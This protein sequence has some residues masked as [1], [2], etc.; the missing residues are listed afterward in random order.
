M[1][2][3]T[4]TLALFLWMISVHL[5]SV[6]QSKSSAGN[7]L[8]PGWYADPEVS[9]FGKEVWIYPTFSAK[10]EQQVFLDAFSSPDLVHWKKHERIIDT[11]AV[12]WAKRA[13]WAPAIVEKGGKYYLFF[14]ANDIQRDG[15][16][17]GIGVAV[18][19]RPEGPFKDLP[20][21]PLIDRFHN[22]AQ[23]IDQFVFED[24]GQWYMI[25]GGWRHCNIV[26]LKEDFTGLLPFPDGSYFRE[27]TPEGYVEGP[28]MFKRNGKYYFMW[29]EGGWTGP[30]Y[31]VAYAISDNP[32]GPFK[33][34]GK[35]LQ[36][37]PAVATG[38]GHHS[39]LHIKENDGY[40]IVY[41]RRPLGETDGNARQ[42]CID[43]LRFDAEG[44]IMPVKIT[45]E[46]VK[47]VKLK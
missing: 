44:R 43:N 29:S 38:A 9:R 2:I 3:K 26:R 36:Q 28:F 4:L 34:I 12:L 20:G 22:G 6:A 13:M 14:S 35:I 37:D 17:G 5:P 18:A 11:N 21:K 25:Y 1:K 46:G 16:I 41:H 30:D 42:T 23:P 8:F 19:D 47:G 39:V 27:I 31:S 33:R 32:L 40:Y 10:Y 24:R 45:H 7:P 15:E